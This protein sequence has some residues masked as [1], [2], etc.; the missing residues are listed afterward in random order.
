MNLAHQRFLA[1][2]LFLGLALAQ[3][4]PAAAQ[5]PALPAQ[6]NSPQ[7]AAQPSA[8]RS[9]TLDAL[10][11]GAWGDCVHDDAPP[12]NAA[13]R[14]LENPSGGQGDSHSGELLL[15]KPPGGCYLV[16]SPIVLTGQGGSADYNY[17][18]SLVGEGRGVTVIRAGTSIDA[19]LLKDAQWNRGHTVT[20]ITFDAAGRAS[21]AIH[22]EN[23]SEL[24]FTRVE[25]LNGRVDDLELDKG[26][27]DFVTDSFFFND[28]TFPEYNIH[29]LSGSTDNEFT[30]NIAWNASYANIAEES[31]GANHFVGNHGYGYGKGSNPY[32]ACPVYSFVTAFQ[33]VWVSN[34]ADCSREA[35][36][37]IGNWS[38]NVTANIIQG[39][40]NHGICVSPQA[41]DVTIVGNQMLF[42]DAA[43]K[44]TTPPAAN[45]VVQG[46]IVDGKVS[47]AGRGVRNP[48]WASASNFGVSSV[49]I[50]N[51]PASNENLWNAVYSS[52]AN[53]TTSIGVGTTQPQ[54]TLDVNGDVRVGAA[55]TACDSNLAGDIRFD[56]STHTFLGCNGTIWVAFAATTPTK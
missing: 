23:G 25:G 13:I 15:P 7:P 14:Q 38:S 47:C 56:A 8:R 12:L 18:I 20:D 21:H 50:N 10:S 32:D 22:L 19:V 37:L 40:E 44:A 9:N 28:S 49:V 11:F 46:E 53:Q 30:N 35:G 39:A 33:S 42:S 51:T 43:G 48:T 55:S 54:A 29:V 17:S 26:G 1:T 24:R 6:P 31:G 3:H 36:F 16:K 2:A 52:T 5:S 27:E 45:A 34:Q 41:G 4:S